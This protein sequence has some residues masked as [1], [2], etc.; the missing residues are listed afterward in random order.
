MKKR[1]GIFLP[2]VRGKKGEKHLLSAFAGREKGVDRERRE[3]RASSSFGKGTYPSLIR[4][5]RGEGKGIEKRRVR[6]SHFCR[7]GKGKGRGNQFF[8]LGK[9]KK[10]GPLHKERKGERRTPHPF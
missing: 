1:E 8:S 5:K 4:K 7:R 2:H 9:K 3:R 6:S 10:E